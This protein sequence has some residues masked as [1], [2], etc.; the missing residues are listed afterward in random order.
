MFSQALF[1]LCYLI[2]VVGV[3]GIASYFALKKWKPE[4]MSLTDE[5]E[6]K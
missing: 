2:T 3:I 1:T 4:F 5:E 6:S